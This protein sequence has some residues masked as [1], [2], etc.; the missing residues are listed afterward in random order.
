MAHQDNS[1]T[2]GYNVTFRFVPP[3]E[4]IERPNRQERG[5]KVVEVGGRQWKVVPGASVEDTYCHLW[6]RL[7]CT[8]GQRPLPGVV[9][10][11]VEGR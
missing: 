2:E 3:F 6:L 7:R 11:A 4:D 9:R 5:S 10:L 1:A 8:R